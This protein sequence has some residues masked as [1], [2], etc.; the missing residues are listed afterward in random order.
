M[1]DLKV[2]DD[3]AGQHDSVAA[4]VH[5]PAMP[6]VLPST[7]W[8][9]SPYLIVEPVTVHTRMG[10]QKERRPLLHPRPSRRDGHEGH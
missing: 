3:R 9:D 6:A 2:P 5:A 7:L 10:G 1:A 4:G 8:R